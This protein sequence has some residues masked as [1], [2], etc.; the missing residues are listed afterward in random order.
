MAIYM[1]RETTP[2]T[3][4]WIYHD[5]VNG[6][7]S[8]SSDGINWMTIADKDI[9]AT[10]AWTTS[11][12]YW[13]RYNFASIPTA[14]TGYYIP[15]KSDWESLMTLW[16][17][18]TSSNSDDL[19]MQHLLIP[20]AWYKTSWWTQ[21]DIWAWLYWSS[22]SVS[23][24]VAWWTRFY[25]SNTFMDMFQHNKNNRLTLREFKTTPV[26]PDSLRTVLYQ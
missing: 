13:E 14:S 3:T 9:G 2:I 23:S 26:Q 8:L 4:A 15:T 24:S 10:V 7:I 25:P 21:S 5:T 20:W 19:I 22:T 16:Q 18:I 1:W 17:W 11:A 12:S 6:L